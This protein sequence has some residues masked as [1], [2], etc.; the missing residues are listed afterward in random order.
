MLEMSVQQAITWMML[1]FKRETQVR[2]L[3]DISIKMEFIQGSNYSE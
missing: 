2:N 3:G 1:T